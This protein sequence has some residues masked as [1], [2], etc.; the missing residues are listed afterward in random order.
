M[1]PEERTQEGYSDA[2]EDNHDVQEGD[3]D[4]QEDYYDEQENDYDDGKKYNALV[5]NYAKFA[6]GHEVAFVGYGTAY[7]YLERCREDYLE[8][9]KALHGELVTSL[10]IDAIFSPDADLETVERGLAEAAQAFLQRVG[11]LLDQEAQK[12]LQEAHQG[13][14]VYG[15]FYSGIVLHNPPVSM[16]KTSD[17]A[18]KIEQAFEDE[19][20]YMLKR[21]MEYEATPYM[22]KVEISGEVYDGGLGSHH[23]V[24]FRG[25][26]P[27]ADGQ[28]VPIKGELRRTQ[29][30]VAIDNMEGWVRLG[31]RTL[32]E[33]GGNFYLIE[34]SSSQSS[35]KGADPGI[36]V[37]G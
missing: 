19:N 17:L 7:G 31:D 12:V 4:G 20:V 28:D 3:Y 37:E 26:L 14:M 35:P 33:M 11:H 32:S 9:N 34:P 29:Y 8:I 6:D 23:I 10:P 1:D 21:I 22:R 36:E 27:G 15:S 16:E 18:Y 25:E 5:L 13:P 2:Q 30:G 24:K